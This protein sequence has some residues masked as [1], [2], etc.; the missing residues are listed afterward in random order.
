MLAEIQE[1]S[2]A[3]M[4]YS[5]DD[6]QT[7]LALALCGE[8]GEV[9]EKRKKQLR[10]DPDGPSDEAVAK[11]LADVLTYLIAYAHELGYTLEQ[12]AELMLAKSERRLREGTIKGSGDDR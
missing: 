5:A 6:V 9:A 7:F 10:R 12:I 2:I 8:A 4:R 3:A 1:R 11:E